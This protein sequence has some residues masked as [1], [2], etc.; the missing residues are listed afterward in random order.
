LTIVQPLVDID[1]QD[2]VKDEDHENSHDDNS[3][4]KTT[5]AP[6][7]NKIASEMPIPPAPDRSSTFC[8]R[9]SED[10]QSVERVDV[11]AHT[12]TLATPAVRHLIKQLGVEIED[13][14]GSGKDGRVTKEDV[15]KHASNRSTPNMISSKRS[16]SSNQEADKAKPLSP[17]QSAMFK[18]MTRSL[19]IPHFLYTMSLDLSSITNIR[20][21]IN[22]RQDPSIPHLSPLPFIIK[23]ISIAFEQYPL[24]NSTLSTP[25][26]S[27]FPSSSSIN[28]VLSQTAITTHQ[29]HSFGIAVATPS[30]LL[31][32][33]LRSVETQ[34]ITDI[35]RS[36]A[37]LSQRAKANQLTMSDLKGASFTISNIGS[38]T[39]SDS[40]GGVVAPVIVSPQV[41]IVG[42]GRSRV[43]P[44]FDDKG[45]L[46]K[47]EELVLSWSADH[48]VVDGAEVAR[49][50]DRVAEILEGGFGELVVMS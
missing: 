39:R 31:V 47:R 21:R 12:K 4:A 42:I 14:K 33:V 35:A 20:Q 43:V 28:D 40:V 41:G 15:Q 17:I 50:G 11:K 34:S 10:I 46:G 3:A 36:I 1:I 29:S 24:L 16:L 5:P 26:S 22:A 30:G 9:G 49:L 19:S 8:T 25:S 13:I 32:P 48:R 44:W 23:A 45:I 7:L 37:S 6:P 2:D 18:T 27:S 38:L